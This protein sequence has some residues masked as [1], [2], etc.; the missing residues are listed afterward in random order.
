MAELIP[1]VVLVLDQ[2]EAVVLP[3]GAALGDLELLL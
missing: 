3:F 2:T 1:A